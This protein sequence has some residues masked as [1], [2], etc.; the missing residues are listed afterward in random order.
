MS[1]RVI[2]GKENW[3]GQK[4]REPRE[5]IAE[6]DRRV[7]AM[8]FLFNRRL[9]VR[10][11]EVIEKKKEE[12]ISLYKPERLAEQLSEIIL[13]SEPAYWFAHDLFYRAVIAA[14][15]EIRPRL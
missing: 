7:K 6:V 2:R 3:F 10:K 13:N 5:D 4:R 8:E 1:A 9:L 11:P 15:K 12:I 14:W